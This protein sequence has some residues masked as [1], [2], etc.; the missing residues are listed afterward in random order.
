M[1]KLVWPF[2][3]SLSRQ[4]LFGFSMSLV[5]VGMAVLGV[6]YWLMRTS[7]AQQVQERARSI[8]QGLVFATEGAIEIGYPS[9]LRRVV[10]NYANLPAVMEI[11][12]VHPNGMSLAN[13]SALTRRQDRPYRL[14]RPQLSAAM[15]RAASTGIDIHLNT[16]ID[17]RAVLVEVF[18]F[19]STLFGQTGQRGLAIA[20]L[21]L[22]QM[23][24]HV[25]QTF[26]T[27]MLTMLAGTLLILA[28]MG[29]A[30]ERLVLKPLNQLK[31]SVALSQEKHSFELPTPLPTHEIGFLAAT[32]D[33][34]FTQARESERSLQLLNESLDRRVEERTIE[35]SQANQQLANEILERQRAEQEI[36]RFFRLSIDLLC[37][38]G[39]DGFF[40]R[41]NPAFTTTLGYS[42]E[43]LKQ[44]PF[45]EFIH[46]EDVP[47]TVAEIEKL[48]Q[49]QPTIAFEN[50]YR[51]KDSSYKWLS[52]VAMPFASEGLL[53][54]AARD[55]TERKQSQAALQQA[56][57][58]LGRANQQLQLE[59]QKSTAKEQELRAFTLELERSNRELQDFAYVSS[60]DLQEPL[61]KIRA[62]GDRLGVKCGQ[63]LT[64][65]GRD[66]NL[67]LTKTWIEPSP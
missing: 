52:W 47:A 63:L 35:L 15:D 53:Y 27:S 28:F 17:D 61:R 10:Q 58:E 18:P 48:R 31:Q 39:M 45:L 19:S 36:E 41:L 12:I 59:I 3:R 32:F 55:I 65:K 51:C 4:L 9:V 54:A 50:R 14:L 16:V 49:G 56:N 5:T 1:S 22:K 7:L 21:D 67:D 34:V 30:I 29:L 24:Q 33:R 6:N 57:L 25:W 42:L 11:A 8:T 43:E 44:Q 40:K 2:Q 46:P 37:I 62:F 13:S 66:Y 26:F 23:Q 20:I 64:D 60:H 38:A